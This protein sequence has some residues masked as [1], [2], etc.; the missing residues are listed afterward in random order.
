MTGSMISPIMVMAGTLISKPIDLLCEWL[1]REANAV[2]P[3]ASELAAQR[4]NE[5]KRVVETGQGTCPY[6]NVFYTNDK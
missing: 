5:L 6:T 4:I 3:F 1:E 2:N